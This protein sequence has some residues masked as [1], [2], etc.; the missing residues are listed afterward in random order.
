[1]EIVDHSIYTYQRQPSRVDL[2]KMWKQPLHK[3]D[4]YV[5]NRHRA[6]KE[7]DSWGQHIVKNTIGQSA[8]YNSGGMFFRDFIPD[9]TVIEHLHCPIQISG[10]TYIDNNPERFNYKFDTLIMV[11]PIAVK[12]N[13]SLVN[14]FTVPGIS[15][16]GPKPNILD[17]TRPNA[18][19]FLSF[20]DWHLFYDRLK[21]SPAEIIDK[22]IAELETIGIYCKHRTVEDS[23]S[24]YV[25]G[26][27]KLE[28]VRQ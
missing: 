14:F 20:S 8:V 24:D 21:F 22:Q 10:M 2:Y 18:R 17:W 11:N 4:Q 23:V 16:I 26:N 28:L 25:N 6:V 13:H 5:Y 3:W 15:R 1:M 7:I 9:I 12:Y 19:I 27:I